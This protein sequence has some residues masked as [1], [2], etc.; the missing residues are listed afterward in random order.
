MIAVIL[1]AMLAAAL[2]YIAKLRERL[3]ARD[4]AAAHYD[5]AVLAF[6]ARQRWEEDVRKATGV[7]HTTLR[8]TP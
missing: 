1:L 3:R 8:S 2:L 4:A 7:D 6:Q 5:A